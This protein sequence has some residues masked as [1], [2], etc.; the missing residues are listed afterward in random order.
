MS[1]IR[2]RRLVL[3]AACGV[4]FAFLVGP[5]ALLPQAK[6][7]FP[8]DPR[9]LFVHD[10]GGNRYIKS[11]GNGQWAEYRG[12]KLYRT[13]KEAG[14]TEKY[15]EIVTDTPQPTTTRLFNDRVMWKTV[16]DK[17]WRQGDT[18]GWKDVNNFWP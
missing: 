13:F 5:S 4:A 17:E 2:T 1:T 3:L 11:L 14:R 10:N 7:Q 9:L 18:G 6:A 8:N 12:G 15:I 16:G